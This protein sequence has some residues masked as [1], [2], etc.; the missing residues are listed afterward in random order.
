MDMDRKSS[1]GEKKKESSIEAEPMETSTG[2]DTSLLGK[3]KLEETQDQEDSGE[4]EVDGDEEEVEEEG[5]EEDSDFYWEKDSFDGREYHSSDNSE[6]SDEDLQERA[7]YYNRTVIETKGFFKSSGKVPMYLW[8]GI[9]VIPHRD[10]EKKMYGGITGHEFIGNMASECVEKHNRRNNKNVR[11]EHLLRANFDPGAKT[12]YYITFA[13]KESDY[14]DAPL[15]EYQ[16]K[17]VWSAGVT[18]PIF[19]RPAPPPKHG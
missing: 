13:A 2:V 1:D 8:S 18:H 14:P 12:K 11:F 17:V 4:E 5:E 15:V 7:R 19:C 9:V 6:Y 10:L 16:A 3:L